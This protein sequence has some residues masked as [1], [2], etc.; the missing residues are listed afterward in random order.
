M[1]PFDK[2]F[3]SRTRLRFA[4]GAGFVGIFLAIP[5]LLTFAKVW[6]ETFAFYGIPPV[7]LYI[8]LPVGYIVSCYLLGLI[9]DIKGFWAGESSHL[10]MSCNPEFLLLVNDIRAIKEKLGIEEKGL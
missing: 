3:I 7:V 10:N 6:A 1:M 8:S 2:N 9:W 4:W 5:T